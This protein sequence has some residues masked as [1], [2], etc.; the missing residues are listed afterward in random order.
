M[1]IE[2]QISPDEACALAVDYTQD[3][4]SKNN[5]DLILHGPVV[6]LSFRW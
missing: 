2:L 1:A 4:L 6:G 3:G 5:L